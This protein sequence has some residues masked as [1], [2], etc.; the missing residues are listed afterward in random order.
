MDAVLRARLQGRRVGVH[1]PLGRGSLRAAARAAEIGAATLQIFSDNPTSWRRR[2]SPPVELPAFRS[3][4]ADEDVAPLTI[5][6]PYLL[7]LAGPDDSIWERSIDALAHELRVG[8]A[9]AAAYVN[10]HLGSHR[11]SGVEAGMRRIGEAVRRAL[12]DAPAGP[13]TPLLALENSAGG[14]DGLGATVEELLAVL[15]A[16]AAAGADVTRVRFSIDTAHAW[17]AGYELSRPDGTDALLRRFLELIGPARLALVHLNDSK[18]ALG[19]HADRHEHLGAG[20]IGTVGLGHVL[21]H[22]VLRTIPFIM[23]TPGMDE[24]CD[25]LNMERARL[26]L[27]N[28]PLEPFPPREG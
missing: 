5:H 9:Y 8:D 11:G 6:G 17:G 2:K 20:Q 19:S 22:E 3:H 15:E 26:L 1:L 14:G 7:N 21:R 23:E 28:E 16:V 10:V 24:G 4:L 18:V 12:D 27:A 25:A 13:G